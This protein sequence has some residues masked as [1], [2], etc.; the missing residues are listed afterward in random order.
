M[1][2][3][4]KLNNTEPFAFLE[5]LPDLVASYGLP[6]IFIII[7][8]ESAGLPLPGETM[9]LTGAVLAGSGNGLEIWAVIATA[10]VAAILGDNLGFW[11]GRR[12][13]LRLLLRYG[14]YVHLD[15]RKLKLGQYLF[16][17]HG[18]KIVFFGRFVALLRTFAAVLAGANRYDVRSFLLWNA[19]GGI[20]WASAMGGLGYAF[21]SQ[22][23]NVLGPVGLG[24][25]AVVVILSVALWRFFKVH[26]ARLS[27]EAE[28]AL[29][30]PLS[31][32][33]MAAS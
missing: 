25:L 23:E 27:V 26:E 5:Q 2:L 32:R 29:P 31:P 14:R 19:L 22:V 6:A 33:E 16:L 15:E 8:L 30:G 24:A 12:W 10:A 21:G 20:V 4:D 9:L 7:L 11:V 18:G 3:L 13:G 17:R 1:W 28:Q